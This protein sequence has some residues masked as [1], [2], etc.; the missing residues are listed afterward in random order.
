MLCIA[1]RFA[2]KYFFVYLTKFNTENIM[3]HLK[4][5]SLMCALYLLSISCTINSH[6]MLRT[7]KNFIFDNIPDIDNPEYEIAINDVV[8]FRL[9]TND[10][11][12]V[13]DMTS[14]NSGNRIMTNQNN[15][16]KYNVRTDSLVELPILGE[17]NIVGK[18]IK[19]AEQMLEELYSKY[20]V[21]PFINLRVNSRRVIIFPGTG[22]SA[23]VV[24]LQFNNTSLIEA[25]AQVGGISKSGKAKKIKLIRQDKDKHLVYLIDLSTIKG[26][27]DASM[28]LKSND[29]IY[30]EPVANYAKEIISDI[31]PILSLISSALF[32]QATILSL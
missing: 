28:V 30:V 8:D 12:E 21:D 23:K 19:Q 22:S 7:D 20:Y 16:I 10:G 29:I 14:N 31:A 6:V 11:F 5:F 18:T 15:I 13:I 3:K 2:V 1:K 25:L 27:N 32:I 17:V 4:I 26:L 24:P 9:F